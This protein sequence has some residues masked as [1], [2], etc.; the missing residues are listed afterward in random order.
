MIGTAED[1]A[2]AVTILMDLIAEG[3]V[4]V[5]RSGGYIG[6]TVVA[7]FYGSEEQAALLERLLDEDDE[8]NDREWS[9]T[10]EN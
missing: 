2:M 9:K 1:G 8:K 5:V 6:I 10:S 3:R 4:E 7:D